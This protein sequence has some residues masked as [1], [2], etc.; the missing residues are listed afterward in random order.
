MKKI[1]AA[2]TILSVLFTSCSTDFKVGADYKDITAIYCL[3]SKS[4][5]AQYVKITKGFYDEKIDNLILAKNSDSLY[6]NNLEVKIEEI[7]NGN[8]VNVFTLPR[9]DLIKEGYVKEPGVFVDSPNYAYKLAQ[10]LNTSNSYRLK[11]KN[12]NTGKEI[13]GE[14]T[15]IDN[16]PNVFS[17]TNPF[18][19]FDRLNF[20]D[21]NKTYNFIFNG[22]SNAAFFDV[23]LRF[24]YQEK[25]TNTLIVTRKYKD[26]PLVQN[27]SATGASVSTIMDNKSFYS[28]LNSELGIAPTYITRYVDTPDLMILAGGQV[29]KTYVDVNS[30]QGGITYDQIKPIYT[31][32]SGE[33]VMGIISTRVTRTLK[34]IAFSEPTFDSII[35]GQYT[36]N[37]QIVGRSTQ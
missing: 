20:A 32:F 13:S 23:V 28:A 5:T 24:W 10:A 26:L 14:T 11:V 3:L 1:I 36:K 12:L 29:L 6:Y 8:V 21:P 34:D 33:N 9:V 7:N 19:N 30:A 25:N 37:L 15:I 16:N 17:I 2:F 31:N 27:I 22:P 4:D 35:N 18:T